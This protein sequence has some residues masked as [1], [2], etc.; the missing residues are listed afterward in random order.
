MNFQQLRI[1]RE[2]VRQDYNLTEV[3]N[4]LFTS[5]PGVSKHIRD[6]EDELGVEI[7]VRRGKRLLGLTEPGQELIGIVERMLIDAQNLRRIADQFSSKETGRLVIAT[8]HTQARYVLPEVITQFR[9]DFPKVHLELHQGSPREIVQ[10]LQEGQAD[11]GIATESLQQV[12][13]LVSFPCYDWHM[14]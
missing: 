11:I 9:H 12:A 7:F 2:A 8:T 4:A 13:D 5:Q 14:R 1:I 6:I 3:A 10:L